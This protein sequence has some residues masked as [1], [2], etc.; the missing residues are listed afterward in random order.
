[1]VLE[2]GWHTSP[3]RER[4]GRPSIQKPLAPTCWGVGF[5]LVFHHQRINQRYLGTSPLRFEDYSLTQIH[6][7]FPSNEAFYRFIFRESKTIVKCRGF[8]ITVL[9]AFPK[10]A[11]VRA[12]K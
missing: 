5:A 4:A 9:G 10:L 1:M 7:L 6:G 3:T 11:L 8:A 2:F 12:W